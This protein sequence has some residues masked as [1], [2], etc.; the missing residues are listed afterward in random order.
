MPEAAELPV[1]AEQVIDSSKVSDHHAIIPTMH[2]KG[3]DVQGLPAG[4]R[5]T[6]LLLAIRLL[7]AIGDTHRYS[8]T[9]ITAK[10]GESVFTAKGKTVIQDGFKAVQKLYKGEQEKEDKDQALPSIAQ[11][12]VLTA[13]D[14]IK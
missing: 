7:V 10:C 11:G 3:F 8:E 2:I 14:E 1:N 13:K 4:E 5:E 9:V 12:D 6:L